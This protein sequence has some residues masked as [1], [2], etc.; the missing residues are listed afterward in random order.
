MAN[1]IYEQMKEEKKNET[2]THIHTHT[3]TLVHETNF[4]VSVQNFK[5]KSNHRTTNHI[6]SLNSFSLSL[7]FFSSIVY[8]KNAHDERNL[9][10]Q[11]LQPYTHM[12]STM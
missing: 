3:F 4:F 8:E 1:H 5:V 12:Q 2:P 11:Q 7:F 9:F 10:G 6:H